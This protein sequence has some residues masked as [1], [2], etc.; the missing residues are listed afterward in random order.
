[1]PHFD[2]IHLETDNNLPDRDEDIA[3]GLNLLFRLPHFKM[4]FPEV[5][6]KKTPADFKPR[7]LT[8]SDSYWMGIYN[9]NLPKESFSNHEFWYYNKML[10]NYNPE[11]K[12]GNPTDFDLKTSIE[13]ND[14]IFIMSTEASLKHVGWG[15]IDEVYNLY[16]NG[17]VAYQKFKLV[18]KKLAEINQIKYV[19]WDDEKWLHQIEVQAKDLHI[20]LDS[21]VNMNVD[22]YY[23]EI[24]KNDP[25]IVKT[26]Q[27]EIE[28]R[29]S[30]ISAQIVE[31]K[32]WKKSV[33]DQSK[34][35]NISFDSCM[36]INALWL[37]KNQM[38]E[39]RVAQIKQQ[40]L[41]NKGWLND[42]T[43]K[44]KKRNISLD[45]CINI[46]ARWMVDEEQKK[47]K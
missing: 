17:P 9:E 24:H 25:P 1:M 41:E 44:A 18:R 13:K 5:E 37:V 38:Y 35:L 10:Y 32:E 33:L 3:A 27:Q 40:I 23:N 29:V 47:E 4:A 15:F 34:K 16:K 6:W 8:V 7:V 2:F 20:S 46:D 45:S 43:E 12:T 30:L 31:S 11:G 14:V 42:V 26:K 39:E 22:Y 28:E 36:R 21:G 19:A